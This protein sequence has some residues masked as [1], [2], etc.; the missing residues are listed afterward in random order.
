MANEFKVKNGIQ[1]PD[2]TVQTSAAPTT[3]KT[4]NS[5]SLTGSGD[6]TLFSGGLI[7]IEKVTTLPGS[8]DAN[9]LYIVTG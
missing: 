5:T 9:T 6:I 8:P 1:F 3:I 7:K 2:N 4:V